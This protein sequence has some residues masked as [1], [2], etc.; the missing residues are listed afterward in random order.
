MSPSRLARTLVEIND[1][2]EVCWI[3]VT[4]KY[5]ILPQDQWGFFFQ[6]SRG[7]ANEVFLEAGGT[8]IVA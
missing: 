4:S 6:G 2:R 1:S 3:R 8:D 7:F 5:K